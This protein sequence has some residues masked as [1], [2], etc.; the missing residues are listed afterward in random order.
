MTF[1]SILNSLINE[2]D[3]TLAKIDSL[4]N[5][6]GSITLLTDSSVSYAIAA[7]TFNETNDE[8][9][10]TQNTAD[11]DGLYKGLYQLAL[12][13]GCSVITVMSHNIVTPDDGI[14]ARYMP[15][16]GSSLINVAN[17][18]S[19]N[20][21]A[22]GKVEFRSKNPFTVTVKLADDCWDY[23]LWTW[24]FRTQGQGES[25]QDVANG[26][27]TD[28]IF[29]SGLGWQ[30]TNSSIGGKIAEIVIP[31]EATWRIRAYSLKTGGT[32]VV[33]LRSVTLRPIA[34]LTTGQTILPVASGAGEFQHCMSFV[35]RTTQIVG[36][37]L[38]GLVSLTLRI[39]SI[40]RK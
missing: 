8:W 20:N 24:D 38:F 6:Q 11:T 3:A 14:P 31:L 18:S 22:I 23:R 27:S 10:L 13:T 32:G 5:G 30:A 7:P 33:T 21:Q 26:G 15:Y 17:I 1:D 40:S 28:G 25:M 35:A 39:H 19:L 36:R 37:W 4:I 16:D 12:S 29:V 9:T 34:W 2:K